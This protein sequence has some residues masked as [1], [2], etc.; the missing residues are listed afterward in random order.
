MTDGKN[1]FGLLYTTFKFLQKVNVSSWCHFTELFISFNI[2]LLRWPSHCLNYF[3]CS[4]SKFL[5]ELSA[6]LLAKKCLPSPFWYYAVLLLQY[7]S[8]LPHCIAL[9]LH[10][11]SSLKSGIK[12]SLIAPTQ[13]KVYFVILF[14][15][16][17]MWSH[18]FQSELPASDPFWFISLASLSFVIPHIK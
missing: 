3:Y 1:P 8:F 17:N 13:L 14:F 9:H 18:L 12:S 11:P 5:S 16:C 15:P 2:F 10:L 4:Y 6:V 7:F